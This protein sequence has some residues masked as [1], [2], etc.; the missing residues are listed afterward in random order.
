MRS[1]YET[2]SECIAL[3]KLPNAQNVILI[4]GLISI[5]LKSQ[6][7]AGPIGLPGLDVWSPVVG[8]DAIDIA[9]VRAPIPHRP[10]TET[11]A[12]GAADRGDAVR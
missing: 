2:R 9:R 3:T 1:R 4:K 12:L 8:E 5:F 11:I 10:G 6:M 7:E